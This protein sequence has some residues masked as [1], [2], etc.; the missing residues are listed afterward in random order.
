[1]N[2]ILAASPKEYRE[3][4]TSALAHSNDKRLR[5]RL[6]DL[7]DRAQPI[8]GE[9]FGNPAEFVQK[10]V[11]TRNYFTHWD[12]AGE[13]VAATGVELFQLSLRLR[14]LRQ[15]LVILELGFTVEACRRV[16][17]QSRQVIHVG[18]QQ[19]ALGDLAAANV[20]AIAYQT[21]DLSQAR[22]PVGDRLPTT[23]QA[24]GW[25]RPPRHPPAPL[26]LAI[27]LGIRRRQR[28]V[29]ASFAPSAMRAPAKVRRIHVRTRGRETMCVRT[30]AA[31]TP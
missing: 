3:W 23:Y 20:G 2:E 9:L 26:P 31:K 25:V 10:V 29:N 21:G 24:P 5:Q 15:I 6:R 27:R 7:I 17:D 13:S 8:I 11:A 16:A 4:L 14:L 30:A 22:K 28:S 1:M 18:A 19:G 12:A